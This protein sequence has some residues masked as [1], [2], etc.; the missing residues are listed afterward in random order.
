[1]KQVLNFLLSLSFF[2]LHARTSVIFQACNQIQFH[3]LELMYFLIASLCTYCFVIVF[4]LWC[5]SPSWMVNH[6]CHH[7][8]C[9]CVSVYIS[10]SIYL[11]IYI[12]IYRC[13]CRCHSF[14]QCWF[15]IDFNTTEWNSMNVLEKRLPQRLHCYLY[16]L[17]LFVSRLQR[18]TKLLGERSGRHVAMTAG[19][20]PDFK[21]GHSE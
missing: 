18:H 12:Y 8:A 13:R 4:T 6:T 21:C 19:F 7:T 16:F 3:F 10:I 5:L 11:Y 1:M 9:W 2:I 14:Y 17:Q 20:L 15:P